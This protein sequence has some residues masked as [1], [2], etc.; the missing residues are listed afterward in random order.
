MPRIMVIR[1]GGRTSLPSG[2][3]TYRALYVLPV[4]SSGAEKVRVYRWEIVAGK[5][6]A[7]VYGRRNGCRGEVGLYLLTD[8]FRQN[9][10]LD[11]AA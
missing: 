9:V 11:R 3:Q 7:G 2:L 1:R 4:V 6:L 5:K 10:H 8:L